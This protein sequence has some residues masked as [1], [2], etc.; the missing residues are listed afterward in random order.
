M[1]SFFEAIF[2]PYV[3]VN[4]YR[5]RLIVGLALFVSF[6]FIDWHIIED[7]EILMHTLLVRYLKLCS[8]AG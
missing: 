7:K 6:G 4:S 2:T 5:Y 3:S 8:L 1:K